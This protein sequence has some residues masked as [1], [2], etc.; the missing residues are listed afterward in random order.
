MGAVIASGDPPLGTSAPTSKFDEYY[1]AQVGIPTLPPIR[2][3]DYAEAPGRP[4]DFE[5]T[6]ANFMET[7]IS[8]IASATGE[9]ADSDR[10]PPK[11]L[12]TASDFAHR[13]QPIGQWWGEGG[14]G[15][16]HIAVCVRLGGFGVF[17]KWLG[18]WI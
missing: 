18:N 16:G 7:R 1:S 10:K 11:E 2:T 17:W 9:W 4:L 14:A 15:T 12:A 8:G 6:G 5:P 13:Q 3:K